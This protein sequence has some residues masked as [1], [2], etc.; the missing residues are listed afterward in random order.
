AGVQGQR[1]WAVPDMLRYL[2]NR[3]A[4]SAA[5]LFGVALITFALLFLLPAD[6]AREIAGH[7][8]T[9]EMV[10][11]VRHEMGL[12]RPLPVQFAAYL[13]RLARGDLGRSYVQRTDVTALL[14]SRLPA[15]LWLLAGA[16][17]AELAIGLPAGILA[18]YRRNRGTDRVVMLFAFLGLSVP[19]FVVAIVLLYVFAAQ[20]GWFPIGG[21]GGFSHLVLPAVTLGIVGAGWYS[22]MMR[23]SMIDVLS[24][25]YVR[26]ARAKGATEPRVVLV[27]ALRNAILPV[28]AMIGLDIG[29]FM[30]GAVVVESVYGWPGVGQLTWQAIQTVDIPVIMAVTL[31]AA[32]G[33][34][35]ANLL[36]D[37]I[38]PL[39]DPRIRLR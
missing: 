1:P 14:L 10:A 31:L 22:R 34:V 35:L 9:P 39:V 6:P 25:D 28:I 12:D 7:S 8:A 18:A 17:A 33:I 16:I 23:S 30:S 27:H 37:M 21:Y 4:Q 11:L 32:A 15:T 5:I 24:Q 13:G 26:T 20:L 2:A 19:Q 38:A 29:S 36:V 3:L